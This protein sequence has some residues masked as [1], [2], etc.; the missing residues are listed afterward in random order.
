MSGEQ[1][2]VV[3]F[4]RLPPVEAISISSIKIINDLRKKEEIYCL[5]QLPRVVGIILRA[6]KLCKMSRSKNKIKSVGPIMKEQSK[7]VT[8]E[9]LPKPGSSDYNTLIQIVSSEETEKSHIIQ[10]LKYLE[11]NICCLDGEY[12]RLITTIINMNW[13]DQGSELTATYQAFMLN[14]VSAHMSYLRLCLKMLVKKFTPDL[15]EGEAVDSPEVKQKIGQRIAH[16][17]S[18]LKSISEIVPM[19]IELL[20]KILEELFPYI[21]KSI[22]VFEHYTQNLLAVSLYLPGLRLGILE[23]IICNMLKLDVRSPRIDISTAICVQED[24]DADS[25]DEAMFEM[26]DE[27][28]PKCQSPKEDDLAKRLSEALPYAGALDVMMALCFR[29]IKSTCLV[30]GQL[31]WEATK[32]LYRELLWIF[33]KYIFPTHESCHLQFLLFYICSLKEALSDGFI[34]FLWKK[35]IDP[36]AQ[37]I[38]RQTAA[39]YIGSFVTRASYLPLS[40]AR[41]MMQLMLKW[42][43]SYLDQSSDFGLSADIEHHGPFYS[44]CQSAFYIFCFMHNSFMHS[45]E[46]HRWGESL[47]FQRVITSK[48]NPLRVC[49]PIVAKTFASATRMHQLAYCDT[50]IER[51]NRYSLPVTSSKFELGGSRKIQLESYFPFDPYLLP[52]SSDHIASLYREFHGSLPD[53]DTVE[54]EDED[55]FLPDEDERTQTTMDVGVMVTKSPVD[56]LHYGVSPGFKHA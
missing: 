24:D 54:D 56:L 49:M 53:I 6:S 44:V 27:P 32:K 22:Y 1:A 48:L 29:Y 28:L 15:N 13:L 35:V 19:S 38:Y 41:Q 34:D 20:P 30:N 40:S 9:F 5:Y 11:Q 14:L 23:L 8:F 31:Q 33:D 47:N 51:N 39:C 26:D 36:S 42:V 45:K 50:I 21:N 4:T 17:H 52:G 46:G 7:P 12:K 55:D 37:C 3:S 16:V 18:L 2:S 10:L 43:H 25:R